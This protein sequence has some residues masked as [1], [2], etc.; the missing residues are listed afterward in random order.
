MTMKRINHEIA[1]LQKEDM[2]GMSLEPTEDNVFHW[3]AS[4]P[5]PEGSP[6]EGGL[7]RLTFELGTDYPFSAPKVVF[8]TRIYHMNI[9]DRGNVCIDVLKQNWSPALS[10]YKVLLSLSSLLTDPNPSTPKMLSIQPYCNSLLDNRGPSRFESQIFDSI[11]NPDKR[12]TVPSIASE[13]VR[14]RQKHDSTAREWTR[15]YALTPKP[16]EPETSVVAQAKSEGKTKASTVS[17]IVRGADS[18][19]SGQVRRSARPQPPQQTN[20]NGEIID[21]TDS[22]DSGSASAGPVEKAR[23]HVGGKRRR[24]AEEDAGGGGSRRRRVD[25]TDSGSVIVIED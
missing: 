21:L 9:S 20:A 10:L 25:A 14:N 5:G 11:T 24:G 2:G 8:V 4:I 1:D 19:G 23:D 22:E 15:L 7:F 12:M 3:K 6:Y 17:P 18:N 16:K 13:Y